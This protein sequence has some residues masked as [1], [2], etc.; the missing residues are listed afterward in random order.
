M[1]YGHA[2]SAACQSQGHGPLFPSPLLVRRRSRSF[3]NCPD[4]TCCWL[5]VA[6]TTFF[7]CNYGMDLVMV[8]CTV[9]GLV[10]SY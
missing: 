10:L 6:K 3:G 4:V 9:K 8:K 5:L 2:K 1:R 7:N